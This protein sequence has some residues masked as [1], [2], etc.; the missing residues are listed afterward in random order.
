MSIMQSL[1]IATT[2]DEAAAQALPALRP[3]VGKHVELTV[4]ETPAPL[5]RLKFE[6]FMPIERPDGVDPVSVEDME[7]AIVD[8]AH[9]RARL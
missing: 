1:R 3:F 7:Q 4:L 5:A 9:G 6:D 8:G 2:V